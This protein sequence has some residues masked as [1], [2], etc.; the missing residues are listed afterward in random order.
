M[1][2]YP[3]EKSLPFRGFAMDE[4]QHVQIKVVKALQASPPVKGYPPV[5]SFAQTGRYYVWWEVHLCFLPD[6]KYHDPDVNI[7][8]IT[9]K[10]GKKLKARNVSQCIARFKTEEDARRFVHHMHQ[11]KNK[12]HF[13]PPL[14]DSGDID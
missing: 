12:K 4:T 5:D 13:L 7:I 2:K 6:P 9:N 14:P 8:G 10:A 3:F 11:S 1:L